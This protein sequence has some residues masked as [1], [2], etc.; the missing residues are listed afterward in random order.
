MAHYDLGNDF[1]HLW[2]DPSM[3]Y[4]AGIFS[5]QNDDLHE[6]QMKKY[7]RIIDALDIRSGDHILEIGCGWGGF[8]R[9]R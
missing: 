1:Y 4:S 8:F 2:L 5:D 3:T 6:A 7:D 9:E